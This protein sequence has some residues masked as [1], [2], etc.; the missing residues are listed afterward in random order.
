[1]NQCR[2]SLSKPRIENRVA[3][4]LRQ[5]MGIEA[6][7]A[8]R[9]RLAHCR[10]PDRWSARLDGTGSYAYVVEMEALAMEGKFILRP[11]QT[12]D[13]DP[14]L[15]QGDAVAAIDTKRRELVPRVSQPHAQHQAAS[16]QIVE[17]NL[18]IR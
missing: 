2:P 9:P 10:D 6:G 13:L 8:M 18:G 1:M 7:G 14:L 3:I 16:A 5:E 11:D 17:E 4:S 15:R 12:Q